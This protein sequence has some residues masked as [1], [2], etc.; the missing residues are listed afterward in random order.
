MSPTF[1]A[2]HEENGRGAFL[3]ATWWWS[4]FVY[5]FILGFELISSSAGR[6]PAILLIAHLGSSA[7]RG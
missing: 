7:R 5:G 4:E 2:G 6:C 3:C 1:H